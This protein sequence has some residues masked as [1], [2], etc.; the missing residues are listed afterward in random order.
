[1]TFFHGYEEIGFPACVT[2]AIKGT[3]GKIPEACASSRCY[4]AGRRSS[5]RRW[6]ALL[7]NSQRRV[8]IPSL[9]RGS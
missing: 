7:F 6:T 1:M 4:W 9:A 3:F 2:L 8:E 5:P